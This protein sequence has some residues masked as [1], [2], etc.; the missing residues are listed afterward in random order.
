[1]RGCTQPRSDDVD[2]CEQCP[3]IRIPEVAGSETECLYCFLP[4]CAKVF[5]NDISY[6]RRKMQWFWMSVNHP[7][8]STGNAGCCVHDH[9]ISKQ[10]F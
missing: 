4:P 7:I 5:Q 8:H 2:R 1:M 6:F 9:D 3:L 10:G